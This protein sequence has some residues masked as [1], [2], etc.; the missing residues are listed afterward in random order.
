M[1]IGDEMFLLLKVD[2]PVVSRP[3]EG[4]Y[5]VVG[6][7][8]ARGLM[9]GVGLHSDRR[10]L[11]CYYHGSSEANGFWSSLLSE[12]IGREKKSV[13][14]PEWHNIK[15]DESDTYEYIK[16]SLPN[17]IESGFVL[18]QIGSHHGHLREKTLCGFW[19]GASIRLTFLRMTSC[20]CKT[21]RNA[22]G[23]YLTLSFF[24]LCWTFPIHDQRVL[25]PTRFV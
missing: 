10:P 1:Q 22:G 23:F 7:C 4:G 25:V 21:R 3:V 12:R 13:R 19:K 20:S 14:S 9:Y 15:A 18:V 17:L 6:C 16:K 24:R 5:K 11:T 8:Y 2:I